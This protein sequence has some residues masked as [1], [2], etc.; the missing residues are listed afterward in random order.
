MCFYYNYFV[1]SI[2][3]LERITGLGVSTK[4][5]INF[6][7]I[8]IFSLSLSVCL[9]LSRS[10]LLFFIIFILFYSFYSFYSYLFFCFCF[11]GSMGGEIALLFSF[12]CFDYYCFVSFIIRLERSTVICKITK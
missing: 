8:F 5:C 4:I 10:F 12:V 2:I 11:L 9:F 3:R 6:Y 1:S 7:L